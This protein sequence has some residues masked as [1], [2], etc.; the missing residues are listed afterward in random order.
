LGVTVQE[1]DFDDPNTVAAALHDP[2]TANPW[3]I[4]AGV[5]ESDLQPGQNYG[6]FIILDH[7]DNAGNVQVIDSY[8]NVDGNQSGRYPFIA[9][10]KAMV[11]SWEPNIDAIGVKVTGRA[12]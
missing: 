4:I 5:K 1:A 6:H 8:T 7:E 12:A 11:D 2:N 3:T 9:V 10:A